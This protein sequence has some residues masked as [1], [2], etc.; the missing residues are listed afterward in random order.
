MLRLFHHAL[1]II[2]YLPRFR[3]IGGEDCPIIRSPILVSLY[4]T[5][6]LILM[7]SVDQNVY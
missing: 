5:D 1:L 3:Y 6:F 4:Q 2:V 7:L